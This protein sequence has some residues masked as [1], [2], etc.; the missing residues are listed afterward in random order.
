MCTIDEPLSIAVHY[1]KAV[2]KYVDADSS[3]T[4]E[5]GLLVS[6]HLTSSLHAEL[7]RKHE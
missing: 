7:R 6:I 4:Y 5:A 3:Q 1:H 2:E